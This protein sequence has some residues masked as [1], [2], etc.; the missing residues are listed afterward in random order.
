MAEQDTN[1]H[2]YFKKKGYE[3]YEGAIS[4]LTMKLCTDYLYIP[5][6]FQSG[7][8]V[9]WKIVCDSR[10]NINNSVISRSFFFWAASAGA[11]CL[12]AVFVK[13][14]RSVVTDLKNRTGSSN[15]LFWWTGFEANWRPSWKDHPKLGVCKQIILWGFWNRFRMQ[16]ICFFRQLQT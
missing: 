9:I 3:N 15:S 7:V 10:S 12:A 5:I 13:G 2:H 16:P 8:L 4:M 6:T 11:K 1:I 14:E